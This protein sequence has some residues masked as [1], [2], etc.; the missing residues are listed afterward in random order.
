MS[1]QSVSI[2]SPSVI[3]AG[4]ITVYRCVGFDGAQATTQGQK[5]LGVA[6]QAAAAAGEAIP[7][8]SLGT[9]VI[10]T[11]GAFAVGDSVICD[12]Q[13]RAIKTTGKLAIAAGATQVTSVAANGVTALVGGDTPEWIVGD[14]LQA[15]AGAGAFVEIMLRR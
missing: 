6:R 1:R 3:A 7:V 9:A 10:E 12:N 14:A 15:S 13:G 4:A 11:G 8:D 2:F 5:V